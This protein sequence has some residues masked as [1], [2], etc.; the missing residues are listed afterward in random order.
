MYL[1]Q[2]GTCVNMAFQL[3]K[4]PFKNPTILDP[5][6]RVL[7]SRTQNYNKPPSIFLRKLH[8]RCIL[9]NDVLNAFPILF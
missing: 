7:V 4:S 2:K 8:V 9:S 3:G 1:H 6:L 5:D